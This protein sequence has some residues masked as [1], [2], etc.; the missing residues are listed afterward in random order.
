MAVAAGLRA[1]VADGPVEG[2]DLE[3][4]LRVRARGLSRRLPGWRGGSL[5]WASPS[6]LPSTFMITNAAIQRTTTRRR[7]R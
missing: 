1:Q 3:G 5:P 2:V 6:A 4:D 7:C